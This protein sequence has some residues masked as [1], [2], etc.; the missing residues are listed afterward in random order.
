MIKMLKNL[1]KSNRFVNEA[2]QL[3]IDVYKPETYKDKI[4]QHPDAVDLK[5]C[6]LFTESQLKYIDDDFKEHLINENFPFEGNNGISTRQMQNIIRDVVLSSKNNMLTVPKF[7]QELEYIIEEGI[8]VN[9]WARRYV[10][11]ETLERHVEKEGDET[12]FSTDT[13]SDSLYN[14]LFGLTIFVEELY[15]NILRNELIISITDR[16]PEAIEADFRKYIQH[17]LLDQANNSKSQKHIMVPRYTYID[18]ISGERIDKPNYEFIKNIESIIMPAPT[19]RYMSTSV[20]SPRS[21]RKEISNKYFAKLNDKAIIPTSELIIESSNDGLLKQFSKEYKLLL[22]NK[23][24]KENINVEELKNLF[25]I[26]QNST[27]DY[28]KYNEIT[29]NFCEKILNN[30]SSN[31][32]YSENTA[33]EAII[34]AIDKKVI[35]LNNLIKKDKRSEK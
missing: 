13:G 26:K 31:F 9:A 19:R 8:Y 7:L 22:S 15:Q 23:K 14:N 3:G 10:D 5:E 11:S 24:I 32:G 12:I 25:Y 18:Q 21:F 34:Y 33:I 4:F 16:N 2:K 6:G 1:P 28:I 27:K 29:R 20:P 30:M 17:V 35:D